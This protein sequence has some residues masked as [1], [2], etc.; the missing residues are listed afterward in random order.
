MDAISHYGGHDRL[1]NM[2]PADEALKVMQ[3]FDRVSRKR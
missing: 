3:R 2:P 1:N